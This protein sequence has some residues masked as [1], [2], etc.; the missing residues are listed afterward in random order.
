MASKSLYVGNVSYSSTEESLLEAFG[1]HQPSN[2]RIIEGRGFAFI[3]VPEDSLE[4]AI[5]EMNGKQVDGRTLTVNEARPRSGGGG[6]G[7]G[8]GGGGG[9]RSGGGGGYSG[10]GGGGYGGGGGGGYGGGGGGRSGGGGGYGGGGGGRGGDRGGSGG[11]YGG[12]K[13]KSY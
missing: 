7:G 13:R 3:D 4:A 2:V 5:A 9:G 11:G 10:G 1:A 12:G 6:G 8:Y